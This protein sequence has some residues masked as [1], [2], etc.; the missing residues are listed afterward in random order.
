MKIADSYFLVIARQFFLLEGSVH[1]GPLTI[2]FLGV[3]IDYMSKSKA[4]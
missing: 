1:G 2:K 4:C 3:L